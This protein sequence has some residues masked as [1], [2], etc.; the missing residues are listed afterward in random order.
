MNV[1]A[2]FDI[3][4]E[5]VELTDI[6]YKEG[7]SCVICKDGR[8][9][10]FRQRGVKDLLYLLKSES[11]ILQGAMIADKVVGKGAAAIMSIGSVASV[12][13]D[14]I[15][16]PALELL[17][18]AHIPVTYSIAVPNIINRTGTGICPVET[19]CMDCKSAAECLP[20]I[21]NFVNKQSNN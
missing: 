10:I 1:T 14:V 19:L 12:Y 21:E 11:G 16:V 3:S 4:M 9:S 7:C 13:A 6:L 2:T 8:I 20:R 5:M 18:K 15:S 17:E